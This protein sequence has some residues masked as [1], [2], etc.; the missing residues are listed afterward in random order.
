[1]NY[2][3]GKN[4]YQQF[5][6]FNVSGISAN[7]D[8]VPWATM[9]HNG[10]DDHTAHVFVNNIDIGRYTT[11]GTI[12]SNYSLGDSVGLA[13]SGNVAGNLSKYYLNLGTLDTFY[14]E[15]ILDNVF[16]E[17]GVSV[18]QSIGIGA[19]AFA[20]VSSGVG[21]TIWYQG[22]NNPGQNRISAVANSGIRTVVSY[23]MP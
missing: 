23:V 15:T 10:L 22:I 14:S 20:G 1:M 18:R 17:P 12:P 19:A 21:N 8:F 4:Y 5:V 2:V 3:I 6:T 11:S 13:V 9:V 16:V 7:M